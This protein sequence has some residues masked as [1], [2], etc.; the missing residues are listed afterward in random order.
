MIVLAFLIAAITSTEMRVAPVAIGIR[1]VT[2][3]FDGV[4]VSPQDGVWRPSPEEVLKAEAAL[5]RFVPGSR[6]AGTRVG[7]QLG[8]YKRHYHGAQSNGRKTI[9]I[10]GLHGEA[11]W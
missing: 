7:K 10:W 3:R 5:E 11:K 6:V 2:P 4:I 9:R 8:K 1:I